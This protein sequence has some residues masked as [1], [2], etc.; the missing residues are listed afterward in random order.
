M[1][2]EEADRFS[3]NMQNDNNDD[4]NGKRPTTTIEAIT[5]ITATLGLFF[6][7]VGLISFMPTVFV[8]S[9]PLGLAYLGI[10]MVL[11]AMVLRLL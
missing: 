11:L 8:Y 9:F 1:T 7:L 10:T 2:N 4:Y 5:Y 6:I 3:R